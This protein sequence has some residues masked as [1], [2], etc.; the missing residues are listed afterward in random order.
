MTAIFSQLG[1]TFTLLEPVEPTSSGPD[2]LILGPPGLFAVTTKGFSAKRIR[3]DGPRFLINGHRAGHVAN[4][5]R[6]AELTSHQ[7]SNVAGTRIQVTPLIVVV[8]AA[9][10]TLK[11]PQVAVT[12]SARIAHWFADLPRTL[13]DDTI[14]FLSAVVESPG[15][16][17]ACSDVGDDSRRHIQ[18]FDRLHEEVDSAH[19]RFRMWLFASASVLVGGIVAVTAALSAPF[20]GLA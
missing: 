10:L 9:S 17:R 7:L 18:R 5:V 4:A 1:P 16:W 6:D 20:F 3:A 14:T 19:H 13:S 12:E 2:H 11:A 15:T 8:D